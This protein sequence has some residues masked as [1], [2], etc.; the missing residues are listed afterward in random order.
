MEKN[1]AKYPGF[2]AVEEQKKAYQDAD[3]EAK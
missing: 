3:L 2:K 1:N